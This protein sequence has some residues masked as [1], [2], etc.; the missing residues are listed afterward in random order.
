[1]DLRQLRYFVAVAERGSFSRAAADLHVAQSALSRHVLALEAEL[2][3]ILLERGV[4]G[5][6]TSAA[7]SLLLEK[8]RYIL[9]E[10]AALK[11]E[12]S[13][14][15]RELTG[16]VRL[17]APGSLAGVLFAPLAQGLARDHPRLRLR[18]TGALTAEALDRLAAGTLDLALVSEPPDSD[19]V[20]WVPLFRERMFAIGPPDSPLLRQPTITLDRLGGTHIVRSV[21]FARHGGLTRDLLGTIEVDTPDSLKAMVRAGLGHAVLPHSALEPD[22]GSGAL[23][24]SEIANMGSLRALA[25]ARGRPQSPATK[26]V[27]ARVRSELAALVASGRILTRGPMLA[28]LTEAGETPEP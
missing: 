26:A 27:A 13:A 12:V 21:E 20:A 14:Q 22:Y 2:G 15:A 28:G 3:A 8:G 25:W 9:G 7:G 23:A 4:R 18:L 1:M 11:V 5:V 17:S 19:A 6:T 10:V 16:L 24:A